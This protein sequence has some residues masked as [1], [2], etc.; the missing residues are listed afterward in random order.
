M[1]NCVIV[2]VYAFVS[3]NHVLHI[4]YLDIEVK[5]EPADVEATGY[6]GKLVASIAGLYSF[7]F[8]SL[9]FRKIMQS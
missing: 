2:L 6:T 8:R 1:W 3:F 7:E 4:N 9:L 5:L